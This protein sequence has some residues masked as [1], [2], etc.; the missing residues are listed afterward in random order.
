MHFACE[1]IHTHTHTHTHMEHTHLYE[2]YSWS[3]LG[4][5]EGGLSD[6]FSHNSAVYRDSC[7]RI[8]IVTSPRD[9]I[10]IVTS[11]I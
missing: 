6:T 8:E 1:P 4:T 10:E 9:S 7:D 5:W 11:P 2:P 3:A